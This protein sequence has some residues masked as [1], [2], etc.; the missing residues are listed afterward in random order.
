MLSTVK[1]S[2]KQQCTGKAACALIRKNAKISGNAKTKII[3][4]TSL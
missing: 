3:G 4:L 2:E 1:L